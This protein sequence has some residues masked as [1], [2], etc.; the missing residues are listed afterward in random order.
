[1]NRKATAIRIEWLG[2]VVDLP[3][4][5]EENEFIKGMN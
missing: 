1:M 2:V 5:I 4:S 3:A